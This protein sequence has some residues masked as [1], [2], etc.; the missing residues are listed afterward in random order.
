[1]K[2]FAVKLGAC[3]L[4]ACMFTA[5]FAGCGKKASTPPREVSATDVTYRDDGAYTTTLTVD[6]D[7]IGNVAASDIEVNYAVFD[8]EGYNTALQNAEQG[9]T[10]SSKDYQEYKTAQVNNVSLAGDSLTINFEDPSADENHTD[11]YLVL[12]P[13][14]ATYGVVDVNFTEYKV[15]PNVDGVLASSATN[16]I[17]LQLDEGEFITNAPKD[18]IS[19]RGSF[20]KM[21]V[22]SVS[23]SGKNLTLQLTGHPAMLAAANSY[24]DGIID[25]DESAIKD[26]GKGVSVKIPIKE[27]SAYFAADELEIV[28]SNVLVPLK[29]IDCGTPI[30]QISA[31]N[32]T[33]DATSDISCTAVRKIDNE[34]LLLTLNVADATDKN[35]VAEK[36]DGKTVKIKDYEFTASFGSATFYPVFDY[37]DTKDNGAKLEFTLELYAK[38]GEFMGALNASE[39]AFGG[40]FAEATDVSVKNTG[41]TTAELIFTVPSKGQ[42]QESLDM[43]GTVVI[44]AGALKNVWGTPTDADVEYT[45]DYAQD[46]MGRDLSN[47]DI[48]TIKDIVGGF[49]NTTFG[50]ITSV[51]SGAISG[52]EAVM[53]ILDITGVCPSKASQTLSI[54][55]DVQKDV[56]TTLT[57]VNR[58]LDIMRDMQ[59]QEYKTALSTFEEK[60]ESLKNS[61]ETISTYLENGRE[62]LGLQ[63]PDTTNEEACKTYATSLINGIQELEADSKG[64]ADTTFKD[65][66]SAYQ[67]LIDTYNTVAGA[68]TQTGSNNPMAIYDTYLTLIYNFETQ[69]YSDRMAQRLNIA[70][71]LRSAFAYVSLWYG[72]NFNNGT[73][74]TAKGLMAKFE[75]MIDNDTDDFF[76]S[77]E[78]WKTPTAGQETDNFTVLKNTTEQT[79]CYVIGRVFKRKTWESCVEMEGAIGP[80]GDNPY[81]FDGCNFDDDQLNNFISRMQGRSITQ[82]LELAGFVKCN[83]DDNK[84]FTTAGVAFKSYSGDDKWHIWYDSKLNFT[85]AQYWY[86][87]IMDYN[88]ETMSTIKTYWDWE[89]KCYQSYACWGAW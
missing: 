13:D 87:Y 22:E 28:G 14:K 65:F 70:Y 1:M 69:T 56:Q 37:V 47:T 66:T 38:S 57:L 85:Y 4:S 25:I 12:L 35:A 9:A 62:Q 80:V 39:F 60:V 8:S 54:L 52:V 84:S 34:T 77:E 20:S 6:G 2:K 45:R 59:K 76:I 32:I 41:D 78:Q 26:A 67:T 83:E 58:Q 88:S 68:A 72:C 74:K 51:A 86:A 64:T 31:S 27:Q 18:V 30:D 15:T 29:V 79:Y 3:A 89:D 16:K 17:T 73:L 48:D 43:D 24:V 46:S 44:K 19:L 55:K 36:L 63:E 82:E 49:G 11:S 71:V 40:D 75:D 10:V 50:T 61:T 5:V 7:T 33:F 21:T 23:S 53:T 42:N 81:K